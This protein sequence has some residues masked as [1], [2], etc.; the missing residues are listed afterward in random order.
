MRDTLLQAVLAAPV[1]ATRWRWNTTIALAVP[2]S[3]RGARIPAALQRMQADDLLAACFPDAAACLDNI[4]GDREVP[5]H[6][7]VNQ[8]VRDCLEEAMDLPGLTQVLSAIH[9]G[10][11]VLVSRDTPEPSPLADEILN[12]RPYAFLDDAPL[13]ERRAQAV[14]RRQPVHAD[15]REFGTLDTAAI[16]RVV[17]EERPD[18]RDAD[19]LHDALLTCGYLAEDAADPSLFAPLSAAG[20]ATRVNLAADTTLASSPV[21]PVLIVAAERLPEVLAVHPRAMLDPAITAPPSRAG[22]QWTRDGALVALL[23]D[24]LTIVGPISAPALGASIG[25]PPSDA[26]HALLALE[27][28]GVVLRGT[29]TNAGRVGGGATGSAVEWCDRRLLARIHRYTLGR[30]RA[31]IA[32]V[33]PADFM[34]FLFA[35]QHAE[36]SSALT[37]PDGLRT[38]IAQLDGLELP[39]RAWE[40]DVLPLRVERY[41][42]TSLDMLCLTGRVGWARLSTGPTQVVGATPIALFLREHADVWF[43][44]RAETVRFKTDATNDARQ[45]D[46]AHERYGVSGMNR[47]GTTRLLDAL[48]ASGAS[49]GH[50]LAAACELD[51]EHLGGA[52][53]E[54]VAAGLIS[55]DGFA[56]LR[57]IIAARPGRRAAHR[58]GRPMVCAAG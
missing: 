18:P 34:R 40:R 14:Q 29:F 27:S 58:F 23:R 42:P 32:P 19:E 12:A 33:T 28:A 3:R 17:D 56:G 43:A 30:M 7:L 37:G 47:T 16:A 46:A 39:A 25:V 51:D 52:L 6:P 5:D 1:F 21:P 8:T 57:S 13:E 9:R 55:S 10:E 35:W 54:L 49:F 48:R 11:L 45:D 44:L 38:V 20:R 22:R 2:R 41:D 24:R 26:E 36:P 31:E 50:E 4:P 53:G 15:A